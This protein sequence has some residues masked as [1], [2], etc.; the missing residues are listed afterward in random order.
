MPDEQHN[1]LEKIRHSLAHIMAASIQKLYPDAKFGVGPVVENGFYY[2]IALED[3]IDPKDLKEIKK[4]MKKLIG[5]KLPFVR[6]EWPIDEAIKYFK[7]QKQDF[8][9]ELLN[10]LKTKGTTA[11]AD[12]GDPDLISNSD[13]KVTTVSVYKTGDFIDLCRGPHVENT[14]EI[15]VD[16]FDLTK[17]A[18]AYWRGNEK[19]PQMQRIYGVAFENKAGLEVYNQMLIE[20]EKRDH[21]KLGKQLDLF[22][23]SDLIGPGLPLWSPRGTVLRNEL[24]RFVQEMRDKHGFEEVTSTHITK[25]DAYITSG[26]WDK[27]KDELFKIKTREGHDFA[28]KPMSC[29][30]HT[31]IFDSRP[32]SYR[33]MPVRYRETTMVYRDEQSGELHGLSRVRSITQDDGHIFCRPSQVEDEVNKV[34]DIIERFWKAFGITLKVRLSTHDTNNMKG[35]LG[36]ISQWNDAVDQL[37]AVIES[38]GIEYTVAPGDA[39]FYGPKIDFIGAD[40]I[41][42]EF[43][44]STIQ[45]DFNMPTRFNLNYIDEKGD[46]ETPIMVHC[47]IN[48][49]LERGIA[50]LIEH[51]AGAFPLWLAPEQVRV[52]PV[53]DKFNKYGQEVALKLKEAGIRVELDDSSESLGKKIRNAEI[54]KVPYALIV[55]E[56]EQKARSVS[57]RR[58]QIGDEGQ[59]KINVLLT[60]LLKSISDKSLN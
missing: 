41:G 3:T 51:F 36:T 4:C 53:S 27:F 29:P 9:V 50:L 47:A 55:G 6:E 43:Q 12:A 32:R 31:Q 44:A 45:L 49:S 13:A 56:K 10:D 57:V 26:H 37:K 60:T 59:Q 5:Q 39:A 58:F 19:N 38:K 46:K 40:S 30:H 22:S 18:G 17:V 34:W 33:D 16:S 28:M 20:A 21:R 35:Y 48:G 23:F 52:L 11:V 7:A 15:D 24:D 8:K 1:Q 54:Y 42:R 25:K 14:S 2:D